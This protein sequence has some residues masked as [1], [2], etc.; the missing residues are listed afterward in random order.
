M[1]QNHQPPKPG[2]CV[3]LKR[4]V[5]GGP[6]GTTFIKA[7]PRSYFFFFKARQTPDIFWR[8]VQFRATCN[9]P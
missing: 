3:I 2:W 4:A 5:F 8:C 6:I 1:S 9:D 7:M